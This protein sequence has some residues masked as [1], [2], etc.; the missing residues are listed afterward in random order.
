M[1]RRSFIGFA[2]ASVGLAAAS[3]LAP[4]ALA[5][6]AYPS[7]AV[8]IV[9]P[10]PAGGSTDAF[11]RLVGER[12]QAL[13]NQ[14][15]VV[16]NRPGAAA[17]IGTEAVAKSAP[18]GYTILLGAS[19]LTLAPHLFTNLPYDPKKDLTPLGAGLSA[20]SAVF[21]AP[22]LE[23][24][25]LDAVLE[26]LKA[27]PDGYNFASAGNATLAHIAAVRF[28]ELTGTKLVHIPYQGTAPA[29]LEVVAGRAHL[30]LESVAAGLPQVKAGAL[31]PLF[32]AGAGRSPSLPDVPTAAEA[33]LKDFIIEPWNVFFVPS[34]TPTDIVSRLNADLAKV[35]DSAETR[36]WLAARESSPILSTPEEFAKRIDAETATWGD[37]IQAA[38]IKVE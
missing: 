26:K 25:T 30:I 37:T 16:E 18:D 3:L 19:Y 22:Q 9:V 38:G 34:A 20:T 29:L 11:A 6:P 21:A 10:F 7:A 23:A 28:Q 31:V 17:A 32:I 35:V 1:K 8:T 13:W 2:T 14:P 15:V 27:K 5:Q 33:G 36:E 12:L 24:K 4:A